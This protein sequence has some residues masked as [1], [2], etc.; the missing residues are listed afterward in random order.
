MHK[1]LLACAYCATTVKVCGEGLYARPLFL[2]RPFYTHCTALNLHMRTHRS[3]IMQ[4]PVGDEE[5]STHVISAYSQRIID[6]YLITPFTKTLAL[7]RRS[8][9][10]QTSTSIY[11]AA[12]ES[13]SALIV[14]KLDSRIDRC[15]TVRSDD[16]TFRCIT[17]STAVRM[18]Q[19]CNT[20]VTWM[21]CLLTVRE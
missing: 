20:A 14:M 11:H 17:V 1:I 4:E 19:Y 9:E 16:R 15:T 12:Y 2:P 18:V 21:L 8:L 3:H 7:P 5:G 13:C 10:R 6:Y